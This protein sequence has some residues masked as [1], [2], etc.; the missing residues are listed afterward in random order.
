MVIRSIMMKKNDDDDDVKE[1][2]GISILPTIIPFKR[3]HGINERILYIY[4]FYKM[5]IV[6]LL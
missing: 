4:F 6:S 2:V 1:K 5:K 3:S